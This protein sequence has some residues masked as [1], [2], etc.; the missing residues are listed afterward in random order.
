MT[1]LTIDQ[2]AIALAAADDGG[3][4][5]FELSPG[6]V[7]TLR[8]A[9][10]ADYV[11]CVV[12]RQPAERAKFL[13][14]VRA[15]AAIGIAEAKADG[16]AGSAPG[17]KDVDPTDAIVAFVESQLDGGPEAMAALCA[18]CI[19]FPANAA[20]EQRLLGYA[21]LPE[22]YAACDRLTRGDTP[23]SHEA[24]SEAVSDLIWGTPT[25]PKPGPS[26]TPGA[27]AVAA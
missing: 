1:K 24:F 19:G 17:A 11:R 27:P 2:L 16:A 25:K 5:E 20:A 22:L 9:S 7:V 12:R 18:V 15:G 23:E 26:E 6:H 8:G 10:P 14:N 4:E 21:R 3:G 13:Q